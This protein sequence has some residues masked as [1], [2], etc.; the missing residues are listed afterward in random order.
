M[1]KQNQTSK[2]KIKIKNK[3]KIVEEI[4]LTKTIKFNLIKN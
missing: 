3:I 1:F 2:I 4:S